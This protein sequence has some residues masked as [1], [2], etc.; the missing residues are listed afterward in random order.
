[1]VSL[2]LPNCAEFVVTWFALARLGAV[3]APVNTAMRGSLL[4]DALALVGSEVLVVHE[5]LWPQFEAVRAELPGLKTLIVVGQPPAGT[6]AWS[7]LLAGGPDGAPPADVHFSSLCLLLYTSGSTGRSKAVRIS[8]RFVLRQARGVIDGLGLRADDVLYCPYPL[9]HLDAAVMTVAPALLL[10]G[11][12]AIG[13]RFSVSRYWDEV[14]AFQA[15]VFDFMGATLTMLWK[16]PPGPRD[17]EHRARLGWGVPLPAWAPQFEQRFGCRLVELYGSTEVGAI[18][19]TPLD[20]PARPGSCGKLRGPWRVMLAD[21]DGFE[22]PVGTPG[23]LLVRPEEPSVLMDGY[24]GQPQESLQALRNQWF[25][26]GDLLRR[27]EDGWY[28]FVGRAKD[29][30]RRRGENIS[31]AEVEQ[32]IEE[33]PAV[34]E[35]AVIGV[36]SELTEEDVMAWVVPRPGQPLRADELA[37]WCGG[38]MA[39]FMVPR[40]VRIVD[41]L[42]KTPTDKV[43]KTRL[44]EQGAAGAWDREAP[45]H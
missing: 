24:W 39:G 2:L 7:A 6:Q 28:Y 4:R 27:D 10:R 40:F 14:R 25:H 43:E 31:A 5:T 15:T 36:P 16:Q 41:E 23:E 30:V 19:Y 13:E 29:V 3:T 34:L 1:N 22:V 11:V 17:R 32:A 18:L 45:S 21:A 9:F 33:H 42:P 26:T 8:H 20:E 44:R 38:R 35:C 37:A 12:A